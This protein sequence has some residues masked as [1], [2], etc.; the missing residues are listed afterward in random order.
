MPSNTEI[1]F[2]VDVAAARAVVIGALEAEGY[3]LSP[4]TPGWSKATRGSMPLTLL[5]G[6]L[7]GKNF[8]VGFLVGERVDE[9]GRA[10]FRIDRDLAT[11][12]VKGGAIGAVRTDKAYVSAVEAV[13]AAA[14]RA[15]VLVEHRTIA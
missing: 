15:G 1:T 8:H 14:R 11:G 2:S 4:S 3:T 12:A 6:G 13:A 10:S 7:A 5:L 9:Q